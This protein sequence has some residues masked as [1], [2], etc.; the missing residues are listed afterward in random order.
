MRAITTISTARLSYS[1]EYIASYLRVD[2]LLRLEF[3]III[4]IIL[5]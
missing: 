4:I 3:S 2:K 5:A 1:L